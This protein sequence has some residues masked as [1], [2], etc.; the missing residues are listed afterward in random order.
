MEGDLFSSRDNGNINWD[1][2]FQVTDN[3]QLTVKGNAEF[4]GNSLLHVKNGSEA[5]IEGNLLINH[6]T[7]AYGEN[8][9]GTDS[10]LTVNGDLKVNAVSSNRSGKLFASSEGSSITVKGN[11]TVTDNSQLFAET[12]SIG[13]PGDNESKTKDEFK[14]VAKT[15]FE[16]NVDV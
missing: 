4:A 10:S 9:V 15:L 3:S 13:A 11:T 8:V 14:N 7:D 5:T 2:D 6:N 12:Y 16:G 1:G